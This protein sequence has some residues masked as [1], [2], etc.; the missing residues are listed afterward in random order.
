[1]LLTGH[2]KQHPCGV[3]RG[4]VARYIHPSPAMQ[5]CRSQTFQVAK[6][7]E[8]AGPAVLDPERTSPHERAVIMNINHDICMI[9]GTRIWES[10][11]AGHWQSSGNFRSSTWAQ[12]VK[13]DC[14]KILL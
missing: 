6:H 8:Q 7:Q 10:K 5:C 13:T 1:M 11:S 12:S 4:M 3:G 14:Q 2:C 9:A